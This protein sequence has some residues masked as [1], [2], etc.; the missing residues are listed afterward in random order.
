M[1]QASDVFL[2]P[3]LVKNLVAVGGFYEQDNRG[4]RRRIMSTR[5]GMK[6]KDALSR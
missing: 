5:Q 1:S 6:E 2:F 3:T 4:I